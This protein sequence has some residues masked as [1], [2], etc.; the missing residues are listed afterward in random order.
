VLF[1]SIVT[2]KMPSDTLKRYDSFLLSNFHPIFASFH[3]YTFATFAKEI[4]PNHT[5]GAGKKCV[6]SHDP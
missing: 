5:L 3:Y 2:A 1:L 6:V 4:S